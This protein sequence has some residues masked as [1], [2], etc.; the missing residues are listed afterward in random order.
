M[1]QQIYLLIHVAVGCRP[2][3]EMLI[4]D[5]SNFGDAEVVTEDIEQIDFDKW[6]KYDLKLDDWRVD[7]ERQ[8]G[9]MR[10]K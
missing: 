10:E 1:H 2:H 3:C 4:Y 5:W 7:R 8:W 9:S 6:G